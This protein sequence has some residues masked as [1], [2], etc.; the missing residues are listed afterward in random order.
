[1]SFASCRPRCAAEPLIARVGDPAAQPDGA[2]PVLLTQVLVPL[3]P[4]GSGG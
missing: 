4:T 3:P 2:R 1:M